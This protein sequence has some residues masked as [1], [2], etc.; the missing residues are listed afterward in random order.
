[1]METNVV[2]VVPG[3]EVTATHGNEDVA[4]VPVETEH[5]GTQGLLNVLAHPPVCGGEIVISVV[6]KP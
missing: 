6:I 3:L 5:S 4:W 1:M 2:I